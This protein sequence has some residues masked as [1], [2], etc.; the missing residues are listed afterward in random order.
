VWAGLTRRKARLTLTVVSVAAAFLLFGLLASVNAA[1]KS[2]G[3]NAAAAHRLVTLAR[4]SYTFG[5]PVGLYGKIQTVP[6]VRAASYVS[7][8]FGTYQTVKHPVGGEAIGPDYLRVFAQYTIAPAALRAFRKT[9]TAVLAGRLLA[10]RYRWKVGQQI[11]IRSPGLPRRN[12]SDVWTFLIAGIYTSKPRLMENAML[13]HWSYLDLGRAARR[14]RVD[15][16]LE[17][18]A[19][20]RQA[21]LVARRIDALS[22]NSSHQTTTQLSSVLAART[23]RQV[24]DLGLIVYGVMGA[25][26]FTLVL[27][28]G[29]A[30][31]YA[32]RERTPEWAI[33]KTVG[34]SSRAILAVVLGESVLL[35]A[36]GALA[37]L[38]FA[39]AV[40]VGV[41]L[42]PGLHVPLAP[43]AELIWAQ[44]L[45]LAVL[46][47]LVAG[48]LP[49]V[50]AARQSVTD[51][52]R[53][54]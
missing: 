33:M 11:P 19:H 7:G 20:T 41:N 46:V 9:Q 23:V 1:F 36:L 26:F 53:N 22:A 44:G 52:L 32:V 48:A 6:G 2:F 51:G 3:Q 10:R 24:A 17:R 43:V 16:F 38:L 35:L 31:A 30:I 15:A 34:F 8:F 42:R 28:T 29:N 47:G 54:L 18:I 13:M 39:H 21:G 25:V 4:D 37:G 45:T 50:R 40:V 12:G 49:A 5:L 27:L 14:G